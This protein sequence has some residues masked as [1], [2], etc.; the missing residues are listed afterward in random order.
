MGMSYI[1]SDSDGKSKHYSFPVDARNAQETYIDWE[2]SLFGQRGHLRLPLNDTDN[3]DLYTVSHMLFHSAYEIDKLAREHEA[4][5]RRQAERL[6][7][8]SA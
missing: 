7:A 1:I 5:A 6:A 8:R 4:R 3:R 2:F